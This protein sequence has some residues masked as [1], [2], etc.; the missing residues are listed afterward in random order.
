[1]NN[2]IFFGFLVLAAL[3]IVV[4]FVFRAQPVSNQ[5]KTGGQGFPG[6]TLTPTSSYKG[7]GSVPFTSTTGEQLEKGGVKAR[8]VIIYT[9]NGFAPAS[10]TIKSGSIV[11]FVN[12]SSRNMQMSLDSSRLV[13][14][15]FN[16]QLPV[17][18]GQTY[19][20]TFVTIGTWRYHNQLNAVDKGAVTVTR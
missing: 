12:N 16:E 11:T 17:G 6:V 3:A 5:Q 20:Y 18:N 10:V 9:D 8:T 7:G 15:G 19:E 13:L 1:M 2:K 14:S 4:I